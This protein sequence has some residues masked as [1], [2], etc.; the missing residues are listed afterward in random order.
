VFKSFA[1]GFSGQHL[2]SLIGLPSQPCGLNAATRYRWLLFGRVRPLVFRHT[3]K[4]LQVFIR[5][6]RYFPPELLLPCKTQLHQAK[7]GSSIR[8]R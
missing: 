8:N 5:E 7:A 2:Q 4:F 3:A 1:I 6:T